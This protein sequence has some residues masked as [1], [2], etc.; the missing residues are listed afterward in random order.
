MFLIEHI[1]KKRTSSNTNKKSWLNNELIKAG[2][3]L[4]NMFWLSNNL[5]SPELKVKD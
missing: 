3:E 4:K 2:G 5:N 1:N